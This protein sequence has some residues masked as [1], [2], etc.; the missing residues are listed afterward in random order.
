MLHVSL[1]FSQIH[2]TEKVKELLVHRQFREEE[3]QMVN[4]KT[5]RCSSSLLMIEMQIKASL[6][7]ET[8]YYRLANHKATENQVLME[9]GD[10]RRNGEALLGG[11]CQPLWKR[12]H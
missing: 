8:I 7:L 2:P 1:K 4:K 6:K 3:T 12:V 5:K 9:C 11:G 10:V